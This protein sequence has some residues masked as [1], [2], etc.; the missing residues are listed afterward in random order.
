MVQA[1]SFNEQR[2]CAETPLKGPDG[3]MQW[4]TG[5][6][7]ERLLTRSREMVSDT[8]PG[9]ISTFHISGYRSSKAA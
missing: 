4:D 9:R 8:H 3:S 5:H 2:R 7:L 6:W 1:L